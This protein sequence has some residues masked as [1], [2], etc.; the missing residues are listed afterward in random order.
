M[1]PHPFAAIAGMMCPD[2]IAELRGENRNGD[3]QADGF[4]DRFLLSFPDPMEATPET[5]RV[6]PDDV[7][8]GYCDVFL[9]L[10][11]MDM[12]SEADGPT[13]TRLRPFFVRFSADGRRAW[14]EFTGTMA[15]RMNALDKF[16]PFRGVLSKLRGYGLRFASLLWCVRRACGQLDPNAPID[17]EVMR[18]ASALVD[19]FER[20]ATRCMG[21]GWADRPIRIATRL[22]AWLSR[23]P[24]MV[25][26]NRTEAFIS[27][28][29]KRDVKAADSLAPAFRIL[30]DHGYLRPL[31]R[32]EN[33]RPG[34]IPET[35]TVNPSWHRSLAE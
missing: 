5:W 23:N 22:L 25:G 24:A 35:Y 20:H 11:G 29:D 9:D 21:R 13:S 27:L 14:E 17:A 3:A 16:D 19:Y 26:F 18:G 2:A 7:E 1:I 32:P 31:D 8:K 4:L 15:A 6:I 12:V 34:P 28:K 10:L 33:A 30:V